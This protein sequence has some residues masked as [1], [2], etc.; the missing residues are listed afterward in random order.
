MK[1]SLFAGSV[2]GAANAEA[3]DFSFLTATKDE[4]LRNSHLERGFLLT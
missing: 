1:N 2:C 3:L 4:F